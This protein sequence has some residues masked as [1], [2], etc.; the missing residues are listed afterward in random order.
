MSDSKKEVGPDSRTLQKKSDGRSDFS[1]TNGLSRVGRKSRTK[2]D[3]SRKNVK[4]KS[5]SRRKKSDKSRPVGQMNKNAPKSHYIS[6]ISLKK[7]DKSRTAK[8]VGQSDKSRTGQKSRTAVRVG[9]SD[10]D[11]PTLSDSDTTPILFEV[12]YFANTKPAKNQK[13]AKNHRFFQKRAKFG[14]FLGSEN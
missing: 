8:K 6:T 7:S 4:K 13:P 1:R 3:K 12:S 9:P 2:S 5:D 14:F 11:R 10:P